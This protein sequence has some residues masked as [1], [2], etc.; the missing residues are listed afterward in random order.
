MKTKRIFF[1]TA[2]LLAV[3]L[4]PVLSGQTQTVTKVSAGYYHS[5]FLKSD[6]S[7]WAM[8]YNFYGQLGDGTTTQRNSPV[9]IVTAPPPPGYNQITGQLLDADNVR[10]T[11]LGIAGTNYALDRTF[12][13]S[14]PINWVPQVTNPAGAGGTLV[15]T[16][17]PDPTMNNFWR[18]RSVP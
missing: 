16:N 1:Q 3:L 12:N 17:T 9:Q 10:L 14:P 8:G 2:L 18:I 7:L 13:L 4:L 5:L 6:G 15:L 11:Y